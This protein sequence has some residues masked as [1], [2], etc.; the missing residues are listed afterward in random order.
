MSGASGGIWEAEVAGGYGKGRKYI[1]SCLKRV[2]RSVNSLY[3]II[4]YPN[5]LD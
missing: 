2:Y 5:Q 4:S 3:M 1:V